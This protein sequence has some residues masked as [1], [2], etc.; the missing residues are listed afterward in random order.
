MFPR[1]YVGGVERK[2]FREFREGL[3]A[4]MEC[5]ARAELSLWGV[6]AALSGDASLKLALWVELAR[7]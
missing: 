5:G 6:P 1:R 4:N 3:R 7:P 2:E